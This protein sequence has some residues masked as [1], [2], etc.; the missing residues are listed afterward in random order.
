MGGTI[1]ESVRPTGGVAT[2][3]LLHVFDRAVMV[4][5]VEDPNER[6]SKARSA[7]TANGEH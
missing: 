5:D 4:E 2:L 3:Q 1:E 6:D 7:T